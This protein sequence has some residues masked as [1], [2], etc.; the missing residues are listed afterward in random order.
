MKVKW[1]IKKNGQACDG[2]SLM[3]GAVL[4]HSGSRDGRLIGETGVQNW[5]YCLKLES[6]NGEGLKD[7]EI[8]PLYGNLSIT[9]VDAKK[10]EWLPEGASVISI[11][12]S[13]NDSTLS[14]GGKSLLRNV[15]NNV[16]GPSKIHVQIHAHASEVGKNA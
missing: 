5:F 4:L 13:H 9:A 8:W 11:P 7:D 6:A 2:N 16:G 12:F 14:E 3:P 10:G 1:Y 15:L